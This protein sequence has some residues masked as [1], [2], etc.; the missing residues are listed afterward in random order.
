MLWSRG[1]AQPYLSGAGCLHVREQVADEVGDQIDPQRPAGAEIA[2]HPDE[3]RNA[4]EHHA[5]IGHGI[6]E[7][8]W[9]AVDSEF[10]VAIGREVEAGSR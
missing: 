9:L 6:G 5:A 1:A 8:E 7:I 4:R 10:D 2:E 3:V